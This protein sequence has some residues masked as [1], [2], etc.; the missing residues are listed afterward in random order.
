M[1]DKN[2]LVSVHISLPVWV[3]EFVAEAAEKEGLSMSQFCSHVLA[4]GARDT[5]GIPK[6]PSPVA[7]IPTVSDVLRTYIDGGSK[8]IG[9]CGNAWPCEY[10]EN[11]SQFIGSAEFCG[12]CNVRVH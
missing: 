7:P 5:I 3:K 1:S 8:L 2:S 10:S 11:T 4:A 6:P 9:P 12:A